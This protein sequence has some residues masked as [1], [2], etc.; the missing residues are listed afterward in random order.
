MTEDP[1]DSALRAARAAAYENSR[2][3]IRRHVP[4]GARR[5]LD[6]GCSSGALGHALKESGGRT[7]PARVVGLELDP[8]YAEA[9]RGRLDEV[10]E[11]DLS[12]ANIRARAEALGPFDCLIAADVLEHLVDPWSVLS[13]YAALLE[14]G[15]TAVVSLP[16][17]RHWETLWQLA[18]R[19]VWPRRAA[20]IFDRDHLRWFTAADA[21][22]LVEQA[23]LEVLGIDRI[24]RVKRDPSPWDHRARHLLRTP[25][26]PFLTFQ[27][28]L[29]GRRP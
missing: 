24:V 8:R 16:N 17:V 20:G 2:P 29:V 23:G 25:L 22:A 6:L 27:M 11:G 19:G 14:P 13:S 5:I 1:S 12:A 18:V 3:E 26:R 15:G 10:I 9:A 28:I 4:Q 21:I 7:A